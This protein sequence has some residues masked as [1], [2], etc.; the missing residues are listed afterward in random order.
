MGGT[1]YRLES[2]LKL[3]KPSFIRRIG[4]A[5]NESLDE[6]YFFDDEELFEVLSDYEE[7]VDSVFEQ[8]YK[9]K[10]GGCKMDNGVEEPFNKHYRPTTFEE[11]SMM[12]ENG[13][14]RTE[15][16]VVWKEFDGE[17][18]YADLFYFPDKQRKNDYFQPK[19]SL[20]MFFEEESVDQAVPL[21][22]GRLYERNQR[23][24]L[25]GKK[26]SENKVDL[27]EYEKSNRR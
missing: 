21:I 2:V 14:S 15:S 18:K 9:S 10:I 12:L 17:G 6:E 20:K 4:S 11:A 16:G 13:W 24:E 8:V 5:F 7:F 25:R 22:Y 23:V 27:E 26:V 1:S 3:E 19:I